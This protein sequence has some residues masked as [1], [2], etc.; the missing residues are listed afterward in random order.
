[1]QKQLTLLEKLIGTMSEKIDIK[2]EKLR[3]SVKTNFYD[4]FGKSLCYEL[5]VVAGLFQK[6]SLISSR[7]K[8]DSQR[9]QRR[10]SRL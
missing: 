10:V 7:Q 1:M 5:S 6:K 2:F 4:V 8:S 3:Y 9:H